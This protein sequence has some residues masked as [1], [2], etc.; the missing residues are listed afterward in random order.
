[1][2]AR[3]CPQ[4]GAPNAPTASFCQYCGSP[5]APTT[6]G[7]LPSAGAGPYPP[8]PPPWG[9]QPYGGPPA[10]WAPPP[11]Q[12]PR[13]RTW[14]WVL[15]GFVAIFLVIFI[16]A[17]FVLVPVAP[18]RVTGIDYQSPDNVCGLNGATDTGFNAS[19]GQVE[20]FEYQVSGNST[21]NGGTAACTISTIS[22]ITAGF[23]ISGANVPLVIP[24]NTTEDFFFNVTCPTSPYTG[25]LTIELT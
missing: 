12:P 18:I 16:I 11:P 14:L 13:R 10:Q 4:C 25:I 7:P 22:A 20:P 6:G 19:E 1:M 8:P 24:I 3:Y 17:A 2:A 21:A 23:S 9:A 15:V 5:L